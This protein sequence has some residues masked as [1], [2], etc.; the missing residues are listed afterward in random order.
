M[1]VASFRKDGSHPHPGIRSIAVLPFENLS[2]D[3]SQDYFADG[4]SDAL[5][6]NLAQI[7]SLRVIS[8][9][10]SLRYR[11]SRKSL[12]EIAKDLNVDAVVEGTF[13][14]SN[15]RVRVTA[16]LIQAPTDRHIWAEA[17]DRKVE[18]ILSM[19]SAIA[20]E[21]ARHVSAVLSSEEQLRLSRSPRITPE[22]QEAYLRARYLM[23]LRGRENLIRAPAYFQ[24]AIT[25]D[26]NFADA[27]AGLAESY[28]MLAAW[29]LADDKEIN[30]KLAV[31]TKAVELDPESSAAHA[32]M[33]LYLRSQMD[34][35]G[36]KREIKRAL[37]LNPNNSNAHKLYGFY[38]AFDGQLQEGIDE[39]MVAV[40]LDPLAAHLHISLG[41]LLSNAR[42]F[43]SAISH[44]QKAME[45][46]PNLTFL[47]L[48][49]GW[50]YAHKGM[51]EEAIR[52]WS[53]YWAK[54]PEI[55]RILISAYE[56]FGYQGYLRALLG[57]DF[58]T[59]FQPMRW[60]HYQRA[61][62]FTEL[63]ENDLAF[64]SLAKAI[65]ERDMDLDELTVDPD[66]EKLRSDSRF[67]GLVARWSHYGL[68]AETSR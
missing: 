30:P 53:L 17:Y 25:K 41:H 9:T 60:S 24:L 14:R 26:P 5:L 20:L 48:N 55:S 39:E 57:R 34:R 7:H 50:T 54:N 22:A 29:G 45:L 43:D 32:A 28:G 1:R 2:G 63:G 65:D 40:D 18:D 58:A 10:S 66:L 37:E 21:V 4:I 64:E 23:N 27:Y 3:P 51:Q 44:W 12:S 42:Q 33:A 61:V 49:V 19:Q 52:E 46:D 35:N 6:T 16:Q 13:S 47:H 38:L 11:D 36:S 62:I 67:P 68:P 31:A 8:R 59:A 56:Q 15:E